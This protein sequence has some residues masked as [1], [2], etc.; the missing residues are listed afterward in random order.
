M[1][2]IL[3]K[4]LRFIIPKTDLQK[5]LDKINELKDNPDNYGLVAEMYLRLHHVHEALIGR[6]ED[7]YHYLCTDMCLKQYNIYR[8]LYIEHKQNK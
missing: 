6:Y 5:E 8:E 3:I 1:I 7:S 2:N 4:I